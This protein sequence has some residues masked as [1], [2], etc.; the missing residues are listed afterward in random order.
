MT[1]D[2]IYE[3]FLWD[4]SYTHEEYEAKISTGINE[5][6]KYKYLYPFIQPVIPKFSKVTWEPCAR[7]V[8]SKSNEELEPYLYLLFEWLQDVNWP[9]AYTIM[10]R[11][12]EMPF[13]LIEGAFKFSKRQAEKDNDQPWLW[14][15]E[16]LYE[17]IGDI[18]I[19]VERK[20]N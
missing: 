6:K 15:L 14:A 19:R 16:D 5:A 20:R 12:A 1:L 7:V 18:N 9:G 13:S 10:E 17:R 11:L 8:V 2:E 4:E 3:S